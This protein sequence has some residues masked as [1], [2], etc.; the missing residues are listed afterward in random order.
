MSTGGTGQ[1]PEALQRRALEVPTEQDQ[2]LLMSDRPDEISFSV[3]LSWNLFKVCN[4][5]NASKSVAETLKSHGYQ[6]TLGSHNPDFERVKA[7]GFFPVRVDIP[8][9]DSVIEAFSTVNKDLGPPN[10]VIYNG[11]YWCHKFLT[12]W[13]SDTSGIEANH[14]GGRYES[15]IFIPV[16]IK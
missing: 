7:E 12:L 11:Q 14:S 1:K 16:S 9:T 2:R 10:I 15:P 8:K 3:I 4:Y 5:S 6:V 13:G